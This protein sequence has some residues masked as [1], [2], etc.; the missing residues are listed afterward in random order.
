M[1]DAFLSFLNFLLLFVFNEDGWGGNI[2]VKLVTSYHH[3]HDHSTRHSCSM[4]NVL[5]VVAIVAV[6]R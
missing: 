5:V 3:Q 4:A 2:V 1:N 6:T